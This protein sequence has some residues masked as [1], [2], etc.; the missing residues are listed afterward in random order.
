MNYGP[1]RVVVRLPRPDDLSGAP[2]R[3]EALAVRVLNAL[4]WADEEQPDLLGVCPLLEGPLLFQKSETPRGAPRDRRSETGLSGPARFGLS[5]QDER[6]WT[7]F[8]DGQGRGRASR[9]DELRRVVVTGMGV[10]SPV[11]VGAD[12]FW[13]ALRQGVS[14][15][16]PI[17]R[18]DASGLPSQIAGEVRGF[19]PL[20]YLPRRDVVRTDT[21][22]HYALIAANEAV[23]DAKLAIASRSERVGASVGT[24]MG[25]VPLLMATYDEYQR[26]GPGAISPYAMPGLL[27]NMAAGWVSLR[28]GTR[29]PIAAAT[30]ACAAGAQA[31][32]DAFR[33]IQHGEADA[34]LAGGT[35]ALLHP[36]V[37][38]AFCALRALS[39]HNAEPARA[40]RPFDRERDGFV[41]AEGCGILVLEEL[42]MARARGAH[43][44]AELVGYGLTADAYHPTAPAVEGPARAM[45]LALADAGL[46]P[47]EIDYINAHG[48]STPQNDINETRAIRQ[49]FGAHAARLA[50]SSTK[51]M[52]GHLIGAAGAVEAIATVLAVKTGL[53]PP[54][55]NYRTPDPECDLDCV[56]NDAR[57][58]A[59][60]AA[61]SNA[62]AFGGT[63]AVLVFAQVDHR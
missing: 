10:V 53:V 24:G 39:T 14:G 8:V 55:I 52:T 4:P 12:A 2:D 18:F 20:A 9:E 59:V 32:G 61:M 34:M 48:T 11:G 22:I 5:S 60:R 31:I 19:D 27:P 46:Q 42:E 37:V 47:E 33:M 56:P 21:F 63:N 26:T 50:V 62:F 17:T 51:S 36:I 6:S 58:M 16:G 15:I 35:D 57:P 29:G 45:A 13:T 44:Y 38:G 7:R 30:T 43:V 23:A 3:Q 41:L 54:T 1:H 40:S 28:A 49:V 25:G